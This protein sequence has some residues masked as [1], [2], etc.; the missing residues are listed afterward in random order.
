MPAAIT[1]GFLNLTLSGRGPVCEE[2]CSGVGGQA[3]RHQLQPGGGTGLPRFSQGTGTVP[4]PKYRFRC[5]TV[6]PWYGT[7]RY[8]YLPVRFKHVT[9]FFRLHYNGS[10]LDDL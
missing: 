8:I 2:D 6:V 1:T 7:G 9:L 5:K 10:D 3:P 4:I